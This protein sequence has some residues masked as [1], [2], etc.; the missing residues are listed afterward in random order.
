[1]VRQRS[2][3]A[4]NRG[5]QR[6]GVPGEPGHYKSRLARK[7]AKRSTGGKKRRPNKGALLPAERFPEGKYRPWD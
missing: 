5:E 2:I 6:A 1:M 3:R 7:A 4:K